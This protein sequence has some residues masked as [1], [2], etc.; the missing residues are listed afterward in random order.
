VQHPVNHR[1][2]DL[3]GSKVLLKLCCWLTCALSCAAAGFRAKQSFSRMTCQ[4]ADLAFTAEPFVKVGP[5]GSGP[6]ITILQLASKSSHICP[7]V[8]QLEWM[9]TSRASHDRPILA[10]VMTSRFNLCPK[11]HIFAKLWWVSRAPSPRMPFVK[12]SATLQSATDAV[13]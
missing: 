11:V 4:D 1:R 8:G 3:V 9:I 5:D 2:C 12:T 13:A 7:F 10:A 6:Y